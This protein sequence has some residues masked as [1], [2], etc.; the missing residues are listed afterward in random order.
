MTLLNIQDKKCWVCGEAD[1]STIHH[2]LPKHLKP[3]NNI[4]VPICENCHNKINCEDILGMY[5]YAHKIQKT[6]KQMEMAILKLNSTIKNKI[7]EKN[8]G[9]KECQEKF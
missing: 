9:I 1:G 4:L 5:S 2:A 6:T 3:K 8:G 7:L